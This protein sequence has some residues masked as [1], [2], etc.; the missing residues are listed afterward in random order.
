MRTMFAASQVDLNER[1]AFLFTGD[2][3]SIVVGETH[4]GERG[5][6]LEGVAVP[7]DAI[8]VIHTHPDVARADPARGVSAIRGGPP[9]G[10]DIAF[11][12]T[13]NLNGVVEDRKARW[14]LPWENP[15]AGYEIAKSE[16]EP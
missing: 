2:D 10:D 4:V 3:G 1:A 9:S 15:A 12:S 8:G 11:L 7:E 5:S 14:Y 6:V 16:R 13:N